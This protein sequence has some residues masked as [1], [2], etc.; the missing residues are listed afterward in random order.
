MRD[1]ADDE[2]G[3]DRGDAA[4]EEKRN[5]WNECADGCRNCGGRCGG[6]WFSKMLLGKPELALRH[7]SDH[8]VRLLGQ[9]LRHFLRFVGI[10]SLQLIKERHLFDLFLGILFN[11]GFFSRNFRFVNFT[12]TFH[13]EVRAR[14]HRQRRRQ[15]ARET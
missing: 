13:R 9:T 11:F 4:H 6:P 7:G 15:H 3:D 5:D 1:D 10:E 12:F 14:A 2:R 8:L